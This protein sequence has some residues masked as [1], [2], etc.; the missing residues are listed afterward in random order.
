MDFWKRFYC[1]DMSTK[2]VSATGDLT[3]WLH[4]PVERSKRATL[5][6]IPL[7]TQLLRVTCWRSQSL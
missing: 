5:K 6:Y 1:I 4:E 2:T 3:K 7:T